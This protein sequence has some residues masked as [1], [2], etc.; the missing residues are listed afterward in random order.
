MITVKL[1]NIAVASEKA[2]K[3]EIDLYEK[4]RE[5]N[6]ALACCVPEDLPTICDLYFLKSQLYKKLGDYRLAGCWL[7]ETLAIYYTFIPNIDHN[8]LWLLYHELGLMKFKDDKPY[9]ALDYFHKALQTIYGKEY[10]CLV[11]FAIVH[12][13]LGYTYYTLGKFDEAEKNYFISF[14]IH[15]EIYPHALE[16][17]TT[18][19]HNMSELNNVISLT[20]ACEINSMLKELTLKENDKGKWVKAVLQE[21]NYNASSQGI[22]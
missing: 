18:L 9:E 7:E 22:I 13:S 12:C 5:V 4:V 11:N 2:I 21:P 14:K 15:C 3:L 19:L 6:Y 8:D 16:D 20:N 10:S 1:K 17:F